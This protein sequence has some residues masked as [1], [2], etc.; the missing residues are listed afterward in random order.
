M[1]KNAFEKWD[2]QVETFKKNRPGESF[3]KYQMDKVAERLKDG[4][5]HPT[6]GGRIDGFEKDWWGAGEPTFRQYRKLFGIGETSKVIDYGCGSLRV[7]AHFIRFLQPESYFGLELSSSLYE[8]GQK[9]IGETILAEKRPRF[10]QVGTAAVD[11]AEAFGADFVYSTAV[12]FH[13]HPDEM[14]LYHRNLVR[15][16][17]KPGARLVFDTKISEQPHRYR[18]RAWSWPLAMYRDALAPLELARTVPV[19]SRVEDGVTIDNQIL[20]FRR[21]G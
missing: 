10:G 13:V 1:S 14:E 16:T 17:T 21:A 8:I 20:E 4:A 6:L 18:E 11:D 19:K 12:A 3:T 7:G 9:M 2:Q 5:S 15:L